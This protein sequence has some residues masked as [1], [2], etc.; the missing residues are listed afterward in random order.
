MDTKRESAIS[1]RTALSGLGSF[2]AAAATISFISPARA[3]TKIRLLT[4]WYAEAEHGGFYQAKATGIYDRAGLDVSIQMGGPQLNGLQLLA[5]G[6]AD[7][8]ISYDIQLLDAVEQGIPAVAIGAVNQ[9]DLIGIVTHPDI[10]SLTGL[11]GHKIL[12][13]QSAHATW[14][15]W[16]RQK[17]GF[18]DDQLGPYAFSMQPFFVDPTVAQQGYLTADPFEENKHNVPCRFFLLADEGYPPYSSTVITTRPFMAANSAAVGAFVKATMEGWRSYLT[19]PAPANALIKIDNPRMPD[20]Q[21][22]FSVD[23]FRATK[24]V[25][26]GDAAKF[27]I[28]IMTEARWRKTHEFLVSSNLLKPTTDWTRAFTLQYVKDLRV[29]A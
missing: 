25:T 26:G 5:A 15:P 20:D 8:I 10:T 24:A 29:F 19:N 22:A 3:A 7:V 16:L 6:N 28:G 13:S 2:A 27:G 17:F 14:W 18:M 21:M 4:N 9:F 12:V 11:K 23:R 1:R